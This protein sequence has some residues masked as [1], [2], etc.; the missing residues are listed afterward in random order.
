MLSNTKYEAPLPRCWRKNTFIILG[1]CYTKKGGSSAATFFRC[2]VS[3]DFLQCYNCVICKRHYPVGIWCQNDVVTTS[4]RRHHVASTLIRRHF[5]VMCPLGK[6]H[7]KWK[8]IIHQRKPIVF[9]PVGCI[10]ETVEI[11]NMIQLGLNVF[12]YENMQTGFWALTG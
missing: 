7:A 11:L 5:Y 6:P 12:F 1:K 3:S 8:Y 9:T 2:N 10:F 4:M